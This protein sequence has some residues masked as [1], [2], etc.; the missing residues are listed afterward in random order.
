M[1]NYIVFYIDHKGK[2]IDSLDY[3]DLNKA[4]NDCLYWKNH[5]ATKNR[6]SEI[7]IRQTRTKDYK[8]ICEIYN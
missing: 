3:N 1:K 2:I 4:I 6:I 7:K 8:T 5:L